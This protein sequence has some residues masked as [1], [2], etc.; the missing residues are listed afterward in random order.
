MRRLARRIKPSSFR[1]L[2]RHDLPPTPRTPLQPSLVLAK[3]ASKRKQTQARSSRRHRRRRSQANASK[4][5]Q[6]GEGESKEMKLT[7]SHRPANMVCLRFARHVSGFASDRNPPKS[8]PWR[9]SIPLD[10]RLR[11][12]LEEAP[13]RAFFAASGKGWR[14]GGEGISPQGARPSIVWYAI[15][16]LSGSGE[17]APQ[18]AWRPLVL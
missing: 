12:R 15:T 5:K 3:N 9:R 11:V 4:R 18:T 7:P 6:E 10:G 14:N 8:A 1:D 2:F 16:I 13:W 17:S